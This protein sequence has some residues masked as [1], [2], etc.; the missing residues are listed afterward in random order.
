MKMRAL[1]ALSWAML[2]AASAESAP[3]ATGGNGAVPVRGMRLECHALTRRF[4][5]IVAVD[6]VDL[7]VEPGE[8]VGLIGHNGAGKTTLFDVVTGFLDAQGG[9]VLLG[10]HDIT[11]RAPHRRAIAGLGRSFQEARLFPS[12]P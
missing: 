2:V 6:A 5:G 8:V 7:V 12:L 9:R 4:G 3:I 1:V 11:G 10:G